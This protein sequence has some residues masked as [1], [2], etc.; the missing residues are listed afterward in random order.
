MRDDAP[1]RDVRA[2]PDKTKLLLYVR[3]GGRCEFDGCNEY[4][5]EH[6]VT[7]D[8]LNVGQMAHIVAFK[9]STQRVLDEAC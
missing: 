6:H 4:L 7:L 2:V 3:A 8:A 1:V 9:E 5:L